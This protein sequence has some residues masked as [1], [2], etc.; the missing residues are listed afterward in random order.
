MKNMTKNR[1]TKRLLRSGI[2]LGLCVLLALSSVSC[3]STVKPQPITVPAVSEPQTPA[4]SPDG[5]VVDLRPQSSTELDTRA[6][7]A[8]TFGVTA[9]VEV[10]ENSEPV[11]AGDALALTPGDTIMSMSEQVTGYTASAGGYIMRLQSALSQAGLQTDAGNEVIRLDTI[12]NS[13]IF[14]LLSAW[15]DG[16][17]TTL[18]VWKA[19]AGD[20]NWTLESQ[21][22][23]YDFYLLFY[24]DDVP[25][26]EF[27]GD[28]YEPDQYFYCWFNTANYTLEMDLVH[29]EYGYAVQ[30]YEP[31]EGVVYRLSY[32]DDGTWDSGIGYATEFYE[33][34]RLIP[35]G[36]DHTYARDWPELENYTPDTFVMIEGSNL[37]VAQNGAQKSYNI[38]T[39]E[40]PST[41]TAPTQTNNSDNGN[42]YSNAAANGNQVAMENAAQP[43]LSEE[44]LAYSRLWHGSQI[45]GSGWSERFALYND[46]SFIWGANQMDGANP[47]RFLAGTWDVRNG[48][49]YL[50]A[51]LVIG[52]EGGEL[53]QNDGT[54][55][56]G[57]A[58]I[59]MNPTVVVYQTDFPLELP[60][61]AITNDS[62]N[63]MDTVML[64]QL[65]CWDYSGQADEAMSDF[66]MS[67]MSTW[68]RAPIQKDKTLPDSAIN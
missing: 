68:N 53:V 21:S 50:N 8:Q 30:L 26:A 18:A 10:K 2:T 67:F 49:L 34:P 35:S 65:Q 54:T 27:Y 7:A 31:R 40:Q 61:S 56:Y 36:V 20:G 60:V 19:L 63:G 64:N 57:S 1:K 44:A 24:L 25:T 23:E 32:T 4:Q 22:G 62:S 16:P 43:V 52:W 58:E 15:A 38:V 17:E 59:I 9:L 51:K 12:G 48:I 11:D 6:S 55:S 14:M 45:L 66:W 37:T 42:D 28:W 13:G 41:T 33:Q 29:T 39:S 46:G 5:A 3:G 47:L